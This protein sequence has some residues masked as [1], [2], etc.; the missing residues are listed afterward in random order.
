[1]LSGNLN[2]KTH[3]KVYSSGNSDAEK[4]KADFATLYKKEKNPPMKKRTKKSHCRC[5]RKT[6]P[7]RKRFSANGPFRTAAI[8]PF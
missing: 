8:L 5:A 3:I 7:I 2:G 4:T 6:G 1:M